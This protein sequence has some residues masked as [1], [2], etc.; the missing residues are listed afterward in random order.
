[1]AC[2]YRFRIGR[3]EV[4]ADTAPADDLDLSWCETGETADK[5]ESGQWEAFDTCVSVWLK[6]AKIGEDWLC[7]SIYETPAD[8]FSDHRSADPM[9]RNCSVMRAARGDNVVIGHYFPDMVREA[10][11]AAREWLASA[12]MGKAA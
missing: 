8:F 3:F 12:A 5:L 10:V 6:G 1:M 7:G 2:M 9:N 4:R 11:A